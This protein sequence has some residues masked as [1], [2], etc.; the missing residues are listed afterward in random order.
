MKT[1]GQDRSTGFPTPFQRPSSGPGL[2]WVMLR[3]RCDL[4]RLLIREGSGARGWAP[5]TPRPLTRLS[6]APAPAPA[7]ARALEAAPLPLHPPG[8]GASIRVEPP[9]QVPLRAEL[10]VPA[11]VP[12][13]S[14]PLD[15]LRFTLLPSEEGLSLIF[16]RGNGGLEKWTALPKH[17]A[18]S[19]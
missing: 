13:R 8:G 14:C 4:R 3:T 19:A 7:R 10:P 16:R 18:E 2:G 15:N 12:S 11:C 9:P 17:C 6:L 5:W 1:W